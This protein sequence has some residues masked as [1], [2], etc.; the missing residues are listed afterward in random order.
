MIEFLQ[1]LF[2]GHS[3]KWVRM[4]DVAVKERQ[5]YIGIIVIQKCEY[6]PS[7]QPS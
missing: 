5:S 2:F 4:E 7:S 6:S 3:H 1:R